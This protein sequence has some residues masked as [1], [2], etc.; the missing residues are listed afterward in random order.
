MAARPNVIV[1][2]IDTARA[3]SFSAYGYERPTS[4]HFDALAREGVLYEQAIAPGCWSLP[5]QVSLLTGLFPSKH[6]AHELH[7][8]Y[9]HAY[10]L[11][12]EV[13]RQ[14]R[15]PHPGRESQ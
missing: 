4:P 2:L 13:L 11:L 7:L 6:G 14:G 1:L 5:S 15:L 12:P 8:S 3:Q 10:P 9:A